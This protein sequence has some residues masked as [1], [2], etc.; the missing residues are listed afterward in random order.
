MLLTGLG[1]M[2]LAGLTLGLGAV[3]IDRSTEDSMGITVLVG[4]TS[5]GLALAG[6]FAVAIAVTGMAMRRPPSAAT[7]YFWGLA[8]IAF[9]VGPLTLDPGDV[10]AQL[11]LLV[12]WPLAMLATVTT[13]ISAVRWR[14]QQ[15]LG[16]PPARQTS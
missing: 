7:V 11:A 3:L 10:A 4:L 15:A 12:A 9:F 13:I 1:A 2:A 14:R 8:G 6:G 16:R 5:F